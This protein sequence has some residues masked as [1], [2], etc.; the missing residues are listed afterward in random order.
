MCAWVQVSFAHDRLVSVWRGGSTFLDHRCH[1]TYGIGTSRGHTI[2]FDVHGL[3]QL[4]SLPRQLRK[5]NPYASRLIKITGRTTIRTQVL[6]SH[7]LK[8]GDLNWIT[9]AGANFGLDLQ[10]KPAQ[11]GTW[12]GNFMMNVITIDLGMI[13][14]AG[15]F[16]AVLFPVA[17]TLI[18][19]PDSAYDLLKDLMP[20]IDLTDRIV[21]EILDSLN[22]TKQYLPNGWET[23][24]L[25]SQQP[26][27]G[28][29]NTSIEKPDVPESVL[30]LEEIGQSLAFI[31]AGETLARSGKA[32][33]DDKPDDEDG[34]SEVESVNPPTEFPNEKG[35]P[36]TSQSATEWV[37]DSQTT[38]EER[39][40]SGL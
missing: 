33:S 2:G 9:V 8:E 18:V 32:S 21:R 3:I 40:Q 24:A 30:K 17:W 37:A 34:P 26:T 35:K 4:L 19:D 36:A 20:G 22:E 10:W 14:V 1:I 39:F 6:N 16:L 5:N 12:L 11:R 28:A 27:R 13:P 25:P 31:I 23:L 29:Q 7:F 38:L 15:P